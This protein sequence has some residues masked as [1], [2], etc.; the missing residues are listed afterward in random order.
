MRSKQV[1]KNEN[2]NS[3]KESIIGQ[4]DLNSLECMERTRKERERK[5]R[6]DLDL[7]GGIEIKRQ[8]N[9]ETRFFQA[10]VS[11]S[12]D[13]KN[14]LARFRSNFTFL[15]VTLFMHVHVR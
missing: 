6:K 7:F 4:I 8:P 1:S 3:N 12:T 5:E 11:Y 9:L 15:M 14:S 2:E 10:G 13:I